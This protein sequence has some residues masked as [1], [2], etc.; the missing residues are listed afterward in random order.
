MT[1]VSL[2]RRSV[3]LFGLTTAAALALTG[4]TA[5]SA[6]ASLDAGALGCV[7]AAS[8]TVPDGKAAK[9]PH[10]FSAAEVAAMEAA[11]AARL[12]ELGLTAGA[13]TTTAMEIPVVFHVL[14]SGDSVDQGNLKRSTIK[15]QIHQMNKAFKGKESKAGVRT[16][17]KFVLDDIVRTTNAD[18]FNL[19]YGGADETAMKSALREG[20]A[21]TL[22]IYSARLSGGLLG[23]ATFPSW[24]QGNPDDDGVVILDQS[25]P[26]GSAVPYDEGDTATHEVGHWM[27]L[28]H[29]FEGGCSGT[30]DQV[31]DTPAEAE[32]AFG[33]P[34]GRDTCTASGTDPVLNYMDYSDDSCMNQYTK[35]QKTRMHD[36]WDAYR[37]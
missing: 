11:T 13:S 10:T 21:G 27:G 14:R 24:Y 17:F 4:L 1:R 30:G 34:I 7:T 22:N 9:D 15:D 26:G 3:G 36:Q 35:D 5:G 31:A 6:S 37:A 33:C 23:W 8:V 12:A 19:S 18:W 25:V 2:A 29:T 16:G 20:D 32:P 28:Y